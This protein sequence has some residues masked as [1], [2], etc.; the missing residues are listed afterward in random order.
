MMYIAVLN[1]IAGIADYS[2]YDTTSVFTISILVWFS[3]AI[4]LY[5]VYVGYTT[6]REPKLDHNHEWIPP[7]LSDPDWD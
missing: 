5:T 4:I 7:K 1:A 3:T 6:H 2:F